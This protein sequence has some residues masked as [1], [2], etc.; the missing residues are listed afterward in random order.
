MR[1]YAI[2]RFLAPFRSSLQRRLITERPEVTADTFQRDLGGAGKQ[3]RVAAFLWNRLRDLAFV[4]DF[5][6][7]P[8]DD[9]LKIYALG[10]EDVRDD[11]IEPLL[12]HLGIAPGDIDF[13]GFDFAALAT[14]KSIFDFARTVT[15]I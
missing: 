6:P 8:G 15:E 1:K 11:I 12:D 5:R 3:E 14:P 13:A 4:P 10:P 7:L 2:C 9:L